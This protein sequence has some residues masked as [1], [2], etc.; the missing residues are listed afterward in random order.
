M[1]LSK[2]EH[3]ELLLAQLEVAE[4]SNALLQMRIRLNEINSRL[5]MAQERLSN[6]RERLNKKYNIALGNTHVVTRSGTIRKI[7]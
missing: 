6:I 7:R 4:L 2:E 5:N 3:I 1:K